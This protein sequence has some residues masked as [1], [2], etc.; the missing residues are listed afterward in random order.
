MAAS[1][2]GAALRLDAAA[3]V[4]P[5]V[6]VHSADPG[7]T[8]ANEIP[9]STRAATSWAAAANAGTRTKTGTVANVAVP[10]ASTVT[11]VGLWTGM[12]PSGVYVDSVELDDPE[13][14]ASAGT[15]AVT[16]RM[17]HPGA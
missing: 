5:Y 17:I 12:P 1:D 9:G 14:F 6:S 11:H 2:A 4:A 15:L 3:P 8:G 13:V 16:P 7:E 10:A